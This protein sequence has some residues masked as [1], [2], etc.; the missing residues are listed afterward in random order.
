MVKNRS[1]LFGFKTFLSMK[2][3]SQR[4][5]SECHNVRTAEE[6]DQLLQDLSSQDPIFWRIARKYHGAKEGEIIKWKKS[7]KNVIYIDGIEANE[8]EYAQ[9]RDE[10][11]FYYTWVEDGEDTGNRIT[12]A[13]TQVDP[14]KES[15][16]TQLFN[17]VACQ[18][19][20]F[21]RVKLEQKI[22]DYGDP[23]EGQYEAS[24]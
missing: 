18:R 17:F 13:V 21:I 9:H 15:F 3:V 22:D 12:N 6:L 7:K 23:L 5:L 16:V 1:S 2:T 24:V 11:G 10:N 14:D 19:L 8:D 4:L 20:D